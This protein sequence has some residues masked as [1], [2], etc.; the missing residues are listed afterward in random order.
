MAEK[1]KRG[2][3][4]KK[5]DNFSEWFTQVIGE[6][7]AQLSDIRYGVQGFIVHRPWAMQMFRKIYELLEAA[8][9]ADGHEPMLFPTVVLEDNLLE[10]KEHAGFMPDVFWIDRAGSEK[11]EKPIALRPTG[12][13]LIYPTYSLWVRGHTDLP[14]KGYQSRITVFRNEKA[15]RPFL[16][17][18]EFMFFETHDVFKDHKG[19]LKQIKT[20]MK[21]MDKIVWKKLKVPFIFF[22]RPQWD[23]FKGADDT[24]A[25]DTLNPDGRRNQISS[26]HDLGQNFAKAFNIQFTDEKG[27]IQYAYQ[28]CFGPGIW[29]IFAAIV[30][31]HGDD[32]GLIVPFDIAPRKVAIVPIYFKDEAVNAKVKEFGKRLEKQLKTFNAIFDDSDHSPG[33]K[34]NQWEMLGVPIRLEIGPKE[35]EA[36]QVTLVRRTRKE[37]EK[38]KLPFLKKRI[39][40][41]GKEID[42]DIEKNAASYF[43]N[44]TKATTSYEELQKIIK[45]F[46]GFVKVPFCTMKVKGKNCADQL[47]TDT[48]GAD[49]CGTPYKIVDKP[50]PGD[51][52]IVCKK[53][54]KYIV[55]VAKSI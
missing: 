54:A 18:R 9:E 10:E 46:R 22:R 2:I 52:C 19:A 15:T 33:Y 13:T 25:S 11:L 7:G 37:K 8:V 34:Y 49:V 12:E 45:E 55:Y 4:V 36:D 23:K 30:A 5:A 43:K 51:F 44:N 6:E 14:L 16:R 47:K 53:P 3:T 28:T 42:A 21:I 26:T 38:V 48:G 27:Q 17:G 35:V 20:D 40:E 32:T 24:Y 39:K 1:E 50:K 29:R 31:I 41:A